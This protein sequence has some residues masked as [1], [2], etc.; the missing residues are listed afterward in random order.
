MRTL[1]ALARRIAAKRVGVRYRRH[2][3]LGQLLGRHLS[4]L[5]VEG[6]I[7]DKEPRVQQYW[8]AVQSGHT[9]LQDAGLLEGEKAVDQHLRASIESDREWSQLGAFRK[10]CG[11]LVEKCAKVPNPRVTQHERVRQRI[12]ERADSDL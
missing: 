3:D 11:K 7:A 4:Q 12:R 6:L 8:L 2:A 5:A 10:G 9:A 1:S